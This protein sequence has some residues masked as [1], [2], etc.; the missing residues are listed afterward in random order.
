MQKTVAE[1]VKVVVCVI[2]TLNSRQKTSSVYNVNV[3]SI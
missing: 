2:N 3:F 1:S